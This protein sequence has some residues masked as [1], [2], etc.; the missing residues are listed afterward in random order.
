MVELFLCCVIDAIVKK[1]FKK[2]FLCSLPI[3]DYKSF[4]LTSV[5]K[6]KKTS[7]SGFKRKDLLKWTYCQPT[8]MY[9]SWNSDFPLISF[10]SV[11]VYF[12]ALLKAKYLC[13]SHFRSVILYKRFYN[14]FNAN[15]D[16]FQI[17]FI[18]VFLESFVTLC[19]LVGSV[20]DHT[21]VKCYLCYM[22][23]VV[24]G[25][26]LIPVAG[27]SDCDVCL[28]GAWECTVWYMLIG[29]QLLH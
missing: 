1:N 14:H 27:Y 11:L 22:C 2:Q 24:Y 21:V 17:E 5:F 28:V 23:C 8:Y 19:N 12:F 13:F 20:E 25:I 7:L 29:R 26:A 6:K 9:C 3:G 10:K 16:L 15:K 4:I 18:Y